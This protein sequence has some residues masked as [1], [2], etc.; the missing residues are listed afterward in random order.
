M[1]V[2]KKDNQNADSKSSTPTEPPNTQVGAPSIEEIAKNAQIVLAS[3]TGFAES[4]K[5]AAAAAVDSNG[6]TAKALSD[7]QAKLVECTTTVTQAM[8]ARTKILDE[9]AVIATKSDHIQKAQEH[10]D[11]V[12]ADLDR[13]LTAAMKQVT[14]AEGYNTK[15][16][17]AAES[18][19][20]LLADVRT[21]KGA[22]DM[23]GAA[24]VTARKAAETAMDLIKGL[25]EKTAEV[26]ASL[27]AY[28]K[29]LGELNTQCATQLKKI[30][31]LLPGATSAGLASSFD[32]RRK[33]FLKPQNRW[34]WLF[35]V[36]VLAIVAVTFTSFLHG[37]QATIPPTYEEL[38]RLWLTRL[39]LIGALVWLAMHAS[40]ESAL[41]KRLEEDYGY[42]AAISSCFE[43][44]KEQMSAID[45]G[46]ASSSALATL[47]K[48]TLDIIATPPGRIYEKHA[49]AVSPTSEL[50]E[51]AK[52]A[53]DL[54]LGIKKLQ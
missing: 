19:T 22:I 4:A 6:L 44:F 5:V 3:I 38:G 20:K 13:A 51:V 33:A 45:T 31:S 14:D 10:A 36:S 46:V 39:P 54:S 32:D 11:K 2:E 18:A 47:L 23:D 17:S 53:T 29:R 42:K 8:A 28:E 30:E 34:Q 50:T 16:Q 21:A 9:Q 27:A 40:H 41:A 35:V 48:N 43:G 1:A 49:L 26:K 25:A 12:R 15:A 24:A 37:L 7:S 52:A